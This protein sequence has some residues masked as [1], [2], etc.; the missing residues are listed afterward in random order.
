MNNYDGDDERPYQGGDFT[1]KYVIG[2]ERQFNPTG[3]TRLGSSLTV[4]WK[5]MH[6]R[7]LQRELKLPRSR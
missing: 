7:W 6:R 3:L 5:W 2:S 4:R 1:F